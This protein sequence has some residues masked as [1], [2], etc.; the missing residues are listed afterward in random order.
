MG[1][2]PSAAPA[3]A[4]EEEFIFPARGGE[5]PEWHNLEYHANERRI[6]AR[7]IAKL[8]LARKANAKGGL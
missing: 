8:L 5:V 2:Q 4:L 3:R 1:Q 7:S 6:M